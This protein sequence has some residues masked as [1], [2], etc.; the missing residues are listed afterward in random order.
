ML[1]LTEI[2]SSYEIEYMTYLKKNDIN[3]AKKVMEKIFKMVD[4]EGVMPSEFRQVHKIFFNL[5]DSYISI[6]D[7][8]NAAKTFEYLVALRAN[9]N[10]IKPRA[11]TLIKNAYNKK[12]NIDNTIKTIK[13]IFGNDKEVMD[14]FNQFNTSHTQINKTENKEIIKNEKNVDLKDRKVIDLALEL[15]DVYEK[16][17]NFIMALQIINDLLKDYP[18]NEDALKMKSRLEI[19]I[20]NNEELNTMPETKNILNQNPINDIINLIDSGDL[21]KANQKS[22]ELISKNP[23]EPKF[24]LLRAVIAYKNK[25]FNAYRNFISYA[26]KLDKN[27]LNDSIYKKYIEK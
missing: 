17:S 23:N 24:W 15:A 20:K 10:Q 11:I 5:F 3:N 19:K 12:I 18:N 6:S 4:E 8:L 25:D 13:N 16:K 21:V 27:I 14:V 26:S 2:L 22:L 9:L 1:S 7:F